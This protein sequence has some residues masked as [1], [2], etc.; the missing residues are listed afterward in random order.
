MARA[1]AGHH[2]PA[3]RSGDF[4]LVHSINPETS[5]SR[6]WVRRFL[7]APKTRLWAGQFQAHPMKG[8]AKVADNITR[9]RG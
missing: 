7:A 4:L 2:H 6:A 1:G 3:N 8:L 5:G 9:A